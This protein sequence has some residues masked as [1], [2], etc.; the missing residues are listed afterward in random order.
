MDHPLPFDDPEVVY[1]VAGR[2]DS[3]RSNPYACW[4]KIARAQL[5]NQ[6]L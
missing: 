5:W 1:E 4:P 3:L 6:L 2:L